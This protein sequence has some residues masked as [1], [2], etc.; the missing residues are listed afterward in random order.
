MVVD[1]NWY[2][3]VHSSSENK[4]C[5]VCMGDKRASVATQLYS[6]GCSHYSVS[7]VVPIG[8]GRWRC[9]YLL[10][11]STL[12]VYTFQLLIDEL[13]FAFPKQSL[14]FV[15]VLPARFIRIRIQCEVVHKILFKFNLSI[16]QV[17]RDSNVEKKLTFKSYLC[18]SILLFFFSLFFCFYLKQKAHVLVLALK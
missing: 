4:S 15:F 12:L 13:S 8:V 14:C 7:R 2:A 6:N 3:R 18:Q 1:S 9:P 11:T 17:K 5:T 16:V 10:N